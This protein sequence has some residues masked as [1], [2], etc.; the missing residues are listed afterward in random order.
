MEENRSERSD[1][2]LRSVN[3]RQ[4]VG[5][6]VIQVIVY[7]VNSIRACPLL[8]FHQ[9]NGGMQLQISCQIRQ[10]QSQ[11]SVHEILCNKQVR[12]LYAK[13]DKAQLYL[14]S[15]GDDFSFL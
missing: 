6:R 13:I 10:G 7:P 11:L 12:D 4:I 9:K 8:R 5:H 14:S 3:G 1:S 2:R 15:E